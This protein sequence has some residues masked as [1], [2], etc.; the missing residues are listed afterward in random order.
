MCKVRRIGWYSLL[1]GLLGSWMVACAADGPQPAT[2]LAADAGSPT[3]T[4][5]ESPSSYDSGTEVKGSTD[6][7]ADA[8]AALDA[9]QS[10]APDGSANGALYKLEPGPHVSEVVERVT[11]RDERRGRDIEVRV[12]YPAE[13]ARSPLILFSHA[14]GA[15]KD[16]YQ[17]LITHW[18]SHGYICLQVDHV[19]SSNFGQM[20][21]SLALSQWRSRPA[22]LSAVLDALPTL[23]ERVPALAGRIDE[24]RIG[25]AG[26]Y[27]GAG[28]TNLLIGA[29]VYDQRKPEDPPEVFAD[30]RIK[31]SLALSPAG[32][33]QG[34]TEL[35]W[36]EVLRPMMVVTGS[37]NISARTGNPAEWRKDPY[38]Y[39]P[40]GGKYLL[41]MDGLTGD[42]DG[43]QD[44]P[45]VG[46]SIVAHVLSTTTAFFD[47]ELRDDLL[48][49]TYLKGGALARVSGGRSTI[50]FK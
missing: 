50:S 39:A 33:G 14:L 25:A 28:S 43:L 19:D 46:S 8:A 42:Y 11:I 38:V 15:S 49:E 16:D 37:E 4:G 12:S 45:E 9:G 21:S 35:S 48:A 27:V 34:M 7:P 29:R 31:L 2:V 26:A 10:T 1:L 22:D 44:E 24:K 18:V 3:S 6:G 36:S 32:L 41:W 23:A 47:A 30:H 13:S 17:H 5:R 40:P 20:P